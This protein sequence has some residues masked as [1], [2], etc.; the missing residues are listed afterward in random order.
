[1]GDPEKGISR[2]SALKRMGAAGAIAWATPVIASM[3]TPAFAQVAASGPCTTLFAPCA[4]PG[5]DCFCVGTVEGP[6]F[7]SND[8]FCGT[9]DD[10]STSADCPSG[11]ACQGGPIGAG[12]C[13]EGV[14]VPPCGTVVPRTN[15][16]GVTGA[17]NRGD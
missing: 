5:E 15:R 12:G 11:W 14:C 17:T 16:H 3:K 1:M 7:C 9:T 10:C 2:R 4:P 13:G 6:G 8:F